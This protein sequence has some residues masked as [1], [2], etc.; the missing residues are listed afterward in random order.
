MGTHTQGKRG[1]ARKSGKK[2]SKPMAINPLLENTKDKKS[3]TKKSIPTILRRIQMIPDSKSEPRLY[4][5]DTNVL[6]NAWDALFQFEEH[7]V[8]IVSQVWKE[9]DKHKKGDYDK[10]WNARGA[11]RAIDTLVAGKKAEEIH[12]G[13]PLIPPAEFLNGKPHTGRLFLDFSKPQVPTTIDIDLSLDEPDD[14]IIMICHTLKEKGRRVVLVSNDGNCR[15]KATIAGIE[16]EEYL[17]DA[18]LSVV[19]EEDIRTGFHHM[20]GDIWEQVETLQT[21]RM[22]HTS[23]YTCAH[24]LFKNVQVHEFLLFADGLKLQV[25]EKPDP[26]DNPKL[27]IAET[28]SDFKSGKISGIRPRNTEQELALQLLTDQR[29]DGVSIAGLAG[30]GKTFLTLAAAIYQT[31]DLKLFDKILITRVTIGSDEDIGFLPGTEKEKM[32]PWMGSFFNNLTMLIGTPHSDG[33][34][35]I[36]TEM[37]REATMALI[38]QRVEIKSLNFMKGST[39]SR[40]FIIIDEAQDLTAKKLKMISTRVGPGSKIVFLG[41]VAQIDDNYV[42]ALTCG[43]STFMR[44]FSD[45]SIAGH[46]TLQRGERS[47]FATEAEGR[48]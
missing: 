47:R 48:L 8:C 24:T 28:F 46:V 9:L 29:I 23:R 31:F 20:P 18:A 37:A 16:T 34:L 27:I 7:D 10:S 40:T 13:I 17:H 44:R 41:N 26:E 35:G 30:S 42:N 14:R 32:A 5:L 2:V 3:R 15:V 19:G 36:N 11:I 6:M 21:E 45:S 39:F 4:V 25:V 33:K 43:L 12:H 22:G 38:E 1:H